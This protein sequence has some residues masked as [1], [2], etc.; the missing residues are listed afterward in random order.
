MY[1]IQLSSWPSEEKANAQASVFADAGFESFVSQRGGYYTVNVGRFE[2][3]KQAR[4]KAESMAH[5]LESMYVIA[6][7]GN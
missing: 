5:M 4:E 2:T 3:K 6:K 1:T 7:V